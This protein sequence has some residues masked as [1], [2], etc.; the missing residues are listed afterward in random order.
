M[1]RKNFFNDDDNDDFEQFDETPS[2][3][4][5]RKNNGEQDDAPQDAYRTRKPYVAKV[6]TPKTISEADLRRKINTRAITYLSR[7]EYSRAELKA[8]LINGFDAYY[9]STDHHEAL[10]EQL[11]NE[12]ERG[13]WQSDER[14]AAQI[15][16]VKG[17][18]FGVTRLK[19]EFKQKGLDDSL[20]Q[21]ELATLKAT[22]FERAQEIWRKKFGTAPDDLKEKARQIRF[23]ASRGFGYEIVSKI[24]KNIDED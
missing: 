21:Q 6:I 12:L 2:G 11:L 13:N 8:K 17:E 19:H 22:E 15:S 14:Y 16:K 4:S 23:M 7:R 1:N 18:R 5:T 9:T 10:I 3:L 24:I 20:V